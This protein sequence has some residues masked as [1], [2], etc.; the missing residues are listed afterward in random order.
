MR[1]LSKKSI[2]SI[3]SLFCIT[4][5]PISTAQSSSSRD[6]PL[7]LVPEHILKKMPEH[8]KEKARAQIRKH[9]EDRA[10]YTR[11][12]H[13][14]NIPGDVARMASLNAI[15]AQI[16]Q[17]GFGADQLGSQTIKKITGAQDKIF[18]I[19]QKTV[20]ITKKKLCDTY[21]G[22]DFSTIDA[23][24][25]ATMVTDMRNRHHKM[26][27]NTY[28]NLLEQMTSADSGFVE[29]R[30]GEMIQNISTVNTNYVYMASDKPELFHEI[31]YNNCFFNGTVV[32]PPQAPST[33]GNA[34]FGIKK[35]S[36]R[37]KN[38][39]KEYQHESENDF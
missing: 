3:L 8:V 6:D 36:I 39:S 32:L 16:T 27:M 7:G 5:I 21:A 31:L 11:Y 23:V 28:H 4:T 30:V 38:K 14:Q 22:H 1:R 25:M 26:V 24:Q 34:L 9:Q 20:K 29:S 18:K 17:G 2:L 15:F 13:A 12:H 10:Q 19:R 33:Q 35:Q 37:V